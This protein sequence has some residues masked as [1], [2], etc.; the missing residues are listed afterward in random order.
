L[1]NRG[2]LAYR[3]ENSTVRLLAAPLLNTEYQILNTRGFCENRATLWLMRP[4]AGG[5]SIKN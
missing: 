5:S 1:K 2:L 4:P 3:N